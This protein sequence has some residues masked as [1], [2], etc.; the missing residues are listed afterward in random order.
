MV[1]NITESS[2]KSLNTFLGESCSYSDC[3][4]E[5]KPLLIVQFSLSGAVFL[6]LTFR[7]LY[8]LIIVAVREEPR[9][10]NVR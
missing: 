5:G 8:E 3:H 4:R 7:A 9:K 10:P 6:I 1:R 2:L